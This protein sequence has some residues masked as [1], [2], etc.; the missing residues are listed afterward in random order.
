MGTVYQGQVDANG[1]SPTLEYQSN[2]YNSQYDNNP[3][4]SSSYE[5]MGG[6]TWFTTSY[7]TYWRWA[8]SYKN[9]TSK[10]Q[11]MTKCSFQACTAHS[12]GQSFKSSNGKWHTVYGAGCQFYC[13]IF[14]AG[15]STIA[16]QSARATLGAINS[17]NASSGGVANKVTEWG[18]KFGSVAVFGAGATASNG[19]CKVAH[20]IEFTFSEEIIIE[21]GEQIFI[22][23]N[24]PTD[25]WN[26]AYGGSEGI[27]VI[28]NVNADP[29]NWEADVEPVAKDMIWVMTSEGWKQERSPF[30]FDGTKWV[31]MES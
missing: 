2:N 3:G 5:L 1:W 8:K 22:V 12:N 18:T 29:T 6:A 11:K 10:K 13:D 28:E 21:P 23:V 14:R 24:V 9:I 19:V 20:T 30:Q 16:Y 25:S 4:A 26:Y 15:S 17:C 7:W 31:K 27:I